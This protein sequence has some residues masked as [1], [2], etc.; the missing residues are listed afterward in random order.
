MKW[1]RH[2]SRRGWQAFGGGVDVVPDSRSDQ[3]KTRC[4][5]LLSH[6]SFG[7][8]SSNPTDGSWMS[9]WDI[10]TGWDSFGSQLDFE[11]PFFFFSCALRSFEVAKL[12]DAFLSC[13][14]AIVCGVRRFHT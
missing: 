6:F 2:P 8:N 1:L 5:I 7:E 14:G 4:G 13:S 11:N 10:T 12:S 9:C 3:R